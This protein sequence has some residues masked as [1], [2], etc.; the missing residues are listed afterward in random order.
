M[1]R[2]CLDYGERY[3]GVAVT[4]YEGKIALRHG[5]ID[6][7][8]EEAFSRLLE[9]FARENV[10][11]VLVGLPLNLARQATRQTDA[12]RTFI[13][14]LQGRLGENVMVD[15]VDETMSS[16]EAERQIR[17]EGGRPQEAHAEAARL[18]LAQ[19]LQKQNLTK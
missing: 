7:T 18:M 5:V 16:I 19:Y 11:Q 8:K 6:Q 10:R 17:G 13:A 4:D 1:V 14:D 9:I 12:T 2:A 15:A 3:I